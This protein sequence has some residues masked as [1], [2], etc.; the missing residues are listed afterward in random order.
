MPRLITFVLTLACVFAMQSQITINGKHVVADQA[1]GLLLCSVAEADFGRDY[2]ALI[3]LDSTA[4]SVT[5]NDAPVSADSIV[6]PAIDADTRLHVDVMRPDS[7][8][9]SGDLQFTFLPIIEFGGTFNRTDYVIVP[10]H[11][12]RPDADDYHVRAK[13]RYR[14]SLTYYNAREKRGYHVKFINDDNEEKRDLKLFGLRNDNSWILDGGGCDNL[15]IRNRI[16]ADLWN[17]M[18]T[19][20]YYSDREPKALSAVHGQLV[21]LF[22]DGDYRGIYNMSEA[23]DRKQMKLKKYDPET[24]EIHGQL[25][26][27]D[28]RSRI[29][30]MDSVPPNMPNGKYANYNLFETKYPDLDEVKPTNYDL[31]Y[32]LGKLCCQADD[33]TFAAQIGDLLDIPVV[34]DSYIFLQTLLAFDN[35]GKNV[36]YGCYDRAESPKLTLG[37]WDFDVS[38]GQNWMWQDMHPYYVGPWHN[39]I[40]DFTNHHRYLLRLIELN[41][42]GFNQRVIDRYHELREGPLA[43]QALIDRFTAA[44]ATINRSGTV[45]REMWRF[46]NDVFLRH[47]V[48][49]NAE[50]EYIKNWIPPHM[51]YLDD[52]VFISQPWPVGDADRSGK[53]DID[54]VNQIVNMII[55]RRPPHGSAD[56]N[57]DQIIDVDDLNNVVNIILDLDNE[58]PDEE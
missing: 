29:T 50:L 46:D 24:L 51:E 20:P 55:G 28:D 48:D 53:V 6:I 37:L 49:I 36:Y 23:L 4:L 14:G 27:A 19:K 39:L 10:F 11:I 15:R 38:F 7:T 41:V 35:Q 57:R 1:R 52:C 26:K 3:A 21:E 2:K 43:T 8:T 54:D 33:S 47:A 34:I 5:I 45:Q 31:L 44:V 25:W 30:L 18:S 40:T 9:W 58:E 32:N 12:M 13:V 22:L 16:C 42:D 56:T 17:D